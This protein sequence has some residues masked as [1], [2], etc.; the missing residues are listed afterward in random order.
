MDAVVYVLF[1]LLLAAISFVAGARYASRRIKRFLSSEKYR[2][3][4]A[5][6]THACFVK[7][8]QDREAKERAQ[9]QAV[10]N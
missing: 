3:E 8:A 1:C 6:Y 4:L 10:T 2:Q 7:F 9:Q 5:E